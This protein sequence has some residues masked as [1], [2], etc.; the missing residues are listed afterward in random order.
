MRTRARS[1]LRSIR[2]RTRVPSV[3]AAAFL[4]T[5]GCAVNP[6]TGDRELSLLSTED[7]ISTGEEHYVPSQQLGGGLYT[8]DPALTEYVT[9]I[10]R[11]VAAVSDRS[12]PY[13]FVVLND[14][15][16]NAWAL[17]GGKIAITRGLLLELDNE[18]ELAAVLGHEIVHAAAKHGAHSMQRG[19]LG[20]LVMLGAAAA[21][22][23]SD[24][25]EIALGAGGVGLQLVNRKYSRKDEREADYYGIKY[26]HAAGYDTAAAVELQEKFVALAKGRDSNWL[27]GLFATHPASTERVKNNRKALAEFP[28]GGNRGRSAY[29][30]RLAYL[31]ARRDAYE[32][33]DRAREML[34]KRP[35][36]ALQVIDDA[37]AQEPREPLFYGIRGQI[38]A[39]RDRYAEALRAY[40]AAIERDTGYFEHYLGRGL[41]YE[42]L[43]QRARARRDLERSNRL[44]PTA[45]ASYSLGRIALA[46]DHRAKAKRL[47]EAAAEARG[48]FGR[49]ARDA[50]VKLDIVDAPGRY[51]AAEPFG[52]NGEVFV[53]VENAARQGLRDVVVRIDAAING[54][55]VRP[56]VREIA[57]LGADAYAIV[58]TG[59]RYGANDAVEAG[60]R[61]VQARPDS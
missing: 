25:A 36:T 41:A 3:L 61:I 60:T 50:F 4:A 52:E 59:I 45:V 10:G 15:S 58:R 35:E 57:R 16:P 22:R 38:L 9:D 11:R 23:D 43:G 28:P 30:D 5:A 34:Q 37:I 49:K 42:K 21:L 17:P 31:R 29:Q 51:V 55:P 53:K 40:D 48:D 7:E 18:A 2:S 14:S 8:V 39:H 1:L 12:L 33:A 32:D 6:V 44:L 20:E 19:M 47:F 46:D 26:L 24:H 27:E 56:R 54:K 13:E